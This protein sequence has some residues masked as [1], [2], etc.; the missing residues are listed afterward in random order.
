M[1][2]RDVSVCVCVCGVCVCVVFVCVV[3]LCVWCLCVWCVCVRAR[4][5]CV[6][7]C[8]HACAYARVFLFS[9]LIPCFGLFVLQAN[10][11]VTRFHEERKTKLSLILDNERWKQA[12]VPTEFQELVRHIEHTGRMGVLPWDRRADTGVCGKV[13]H[14]GLEHRCVDL[15]VL[16]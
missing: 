12:D 3:Y 10:R 1:W 13:V 4:A 11:F 2:V 16:V 15:R 5:R 9:I 6:R 8:M 14:A 7:A